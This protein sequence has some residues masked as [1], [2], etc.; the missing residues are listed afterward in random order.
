MSLIDFLEVSPIPRSLDQAVRLLRAGMAQA[1]ANLGG[2]GYETG[3]D[4]IKRLK[5]DEFVSE[6][7]DLGGW[8]GMAWRLWSKNNPISGAFGPTRSTE[9]MFH[10]L[11]REAHGHHWSLA[12]L[13]EEI[14]NQKKFSVHLSHL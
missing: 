3:I 5:E 2:D 7:D 12:S 13:A 8:L 4:F 1:D 10:A 14:K 9:L 6:M 11:W